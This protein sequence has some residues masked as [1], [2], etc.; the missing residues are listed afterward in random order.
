MQCSAVQCDAMRHR[1]CIYLSKPT[2]HNRDA[3]EL[4]RTYD[5]HVLVGESS[6]SPA[7]LGDSKF[8]NILSASNGC[9][10]C[11]PLVCSRSCV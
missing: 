8:P 3:D 4:P 9:V 7:K 11:L 6:P 2:A 10:L 5:T 1:N